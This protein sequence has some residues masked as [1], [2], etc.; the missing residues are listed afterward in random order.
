MLLADAVVFALG[1]YWLAMFAVLPDGSAGIGVEK[2]MTGGVLP[3]V[4]GDVV[5]LALAA[6]MVSAGA[7]LVRR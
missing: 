2:A 5:K 4:F 7:R 1:F 6:A 3:F